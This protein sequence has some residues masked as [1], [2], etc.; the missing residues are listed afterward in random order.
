VELSGSELFK[1][2]ITMASITY[3][4]V[5]GILAKKVWDVPKT[6]QKHLEE[7]S[8]KLEARLLRIDEESKT[9]HRRL[10]V[11]DRI[12]SKLAGRDFDSRAIADSGV[13]PDIKTRVV[14]TDG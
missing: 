3:S 6:V 4:V 12:T 1:I 11:Q 5:F 8:N 10:N 13:Y 14:G 2:I 9:A 7:Y